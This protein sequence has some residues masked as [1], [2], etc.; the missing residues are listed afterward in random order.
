MAINSK[1]IIRY[2]LFGIALLIAVSSLPV[3]NTAS[4]AKTKVTFRPPA[5]QAPKSTTGGASR[6]SDMCGFST[7]QNTSSTVVTPLLPN[8]NIGLTT[9]ERPNIFVYVPKTIAKKAFFSV[10]D[11]N[12]NHYYQ[13]T[14]DLPEKPGVMEIKLPDSAPQ[15][16]TNK[17]YKWSLAVICGE[18]LEPD[19]P[20][21]SGWIRRVESNHNLSNQPSN[22]A[23]SKNS[24]ESVSKLATNGLWYDSLTALAQL[25]REQPSNQNLADSWQELLKS[26]NLNEIAKEPLV[27]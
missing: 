17:N 13:T 22:Q 19:S 5:N 8:T 26:A 12:T 6:D 25:R 27:N 24:L 11:E 16:K 18:S 10:Q 3:L 2:A 14:I 4:Y 1:S 23:S 7:A 21:V 20:L 9:T 15:L